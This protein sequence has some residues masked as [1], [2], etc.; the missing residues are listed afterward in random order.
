M[1][2]EEQRI[3]VDYEAWAVQKKELADSHKKMG[4]L[5]LIT[6]VIAM[7]GIFSTTAA[8][9]SKIVYKDRVITHNIVYKPRLNAVLIDIYERKIDKLHEAPGLLNVDQKSKENKEIE[10]FL[11]SEAES[12]PLEMEDAYKRSGWIRLD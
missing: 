2:M 6:L 8:L 1:Q 7:V 3:D 11:R 9:N 5:G 4:Q 10:R 12:H